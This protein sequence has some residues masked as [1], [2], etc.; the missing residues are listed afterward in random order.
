MP[1]RGERE[2]DPALIEYRLSLVEKIVRELDGKVDRL[3]WAVT[4]AALSFAAS[5]AVVLITYL[6]SGPR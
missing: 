6:N 4:A 2:D 5:A 1:T 3:V